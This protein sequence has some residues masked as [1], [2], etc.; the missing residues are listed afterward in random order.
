MFSCIHMY[1]VVIQLYIGDIMV[2]RTSYFCVGD[3]SVGSG[4]DH[5][6]PQNILKARNRRIEVVRG[7]G[8][9]AEWRLVEKFSLGVG[10]LPLGMFK[11]HAIAV[12]I[13]DNLR[14]QSY[15]REEEI[16]AL[17]R[18]KREFVKFIDGLVVPFLITKADDKLFKAK[19]AKSL[20][21][22][23]IKKKKSKVE[24][25]A[26]RVSRMRLRKK[27]DREFQLMMRK[28]AEFKNKMEAKDEGQRNSAN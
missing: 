4:I 8:W 6:D 12:G 20:L 28:R 13:F 16:M 3:Y 11:D 23:E 17:F 25:R 24:D 19:N 14:R 9:E 10:D 5:L 18:L 7:F 27:N 1:S 2:K 26:F 21:N 15:T 22:K